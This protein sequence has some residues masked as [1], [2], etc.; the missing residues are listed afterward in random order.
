MKNIYDIAAK[1]VG[2][3]RKTKAEFRKSLADKGFS[4]EEIDKV[5][6]EFE[7]D[8]YISDRNYSADYFSYAYNKGWAKKRICFELR[9]KG[10]LAEDIDSGF[11]DY[12]QLETPDEKNKAY[13][14]VK[15]YLDE[16]DFDNGEMVEKAKAA[17][18]RKLSSYGYDI[19]TIYGAI[20]RVETEIV[21]SEGPM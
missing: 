15:K 21:G 8:G 17:I 4:E 13:E 3:G 18:V 19:Y 5:T 12:I 9:K 6:E 7:K 10:I 14:L 20:E 16:D 11:S 2:G 1:L